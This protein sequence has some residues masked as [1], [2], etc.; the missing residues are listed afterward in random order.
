MDGLYVEH[1][2]G[3]GAGVLTKCYSTI[4]LY[5]IQQGNNDI[6]HC[7]DRFVGVFFKCLN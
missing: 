1:S 7:H 6:I 3:E 5:D 2:H 4:Y